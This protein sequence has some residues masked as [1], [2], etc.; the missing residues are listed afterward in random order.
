MSINVDSAIYFIYEGGEFLLFW[1]EISDGCAWNAWKGCCV[2]MWDGKY[3]S[4]DGADDER[5]WSHI[6]EL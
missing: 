4:K 6:D 2:S 3:K 1:E 5:E